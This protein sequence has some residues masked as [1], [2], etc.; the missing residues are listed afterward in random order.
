[1]SQENVEIV[2]R[3]GEAFNAHDVE[4]LCE[5][6]GADIEFAPYP[7]TA[8]ETTTFTGHDGL[9]SYFVEADAAWETLQLRAYEVRDLGSRVLSVGELHGQG[10]LSGLALDTPLASLVELRDGKV[11]RVETFTSAQQAL[12]VMGLAE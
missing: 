7:A 8:L 3:F 10:R 9:R 5:L 2:R 12:E 4:A 6:A 1:M 11:V